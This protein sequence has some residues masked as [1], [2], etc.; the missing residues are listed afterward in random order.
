MAWQDRL[1]EAAY[2]SP[3]GQRFTFSYEN[4]SKSVTKR[5]SA[6]NFPDADGTYIQDL[7]RTGRRYPMRL[8]FHGDNYDLEAAAFDAALLEVGAGRLEH[9]MYGTVDVVPFGDITRRDDLKT[10]ANQAIIEVKFWE[11]TDILLPS[12]Q[13]DP[14]TGVLNAISE[15]N[16]AAAGQFEE[17][18][19]LDNAS[20]VASFKNRF[21]AVLDTTGATLKGVAEA[22]DDVRQ[23][24][25]AVYDSVNSS[26]D[27][28]VSEPLTL[29]TQTLIFIQTPARALAN[30]RARLSAYSDMAGALISGPNAI[31]TPSL[32]ASNSNA[33][34]N[35]NLYASTA[36]TGAVVSVVN[37]TFETKTE[38]LEAAE[39]I[40]DLAEQVNTWRDDNLV[41][42]SEIDTGEAYQQLQEAV[43]LA[44]GF[45]VQ[46]SFSLKQE[47]RIVLDRAR[48][49]VDLVAGLYGEVDTQLDFLINS[50]SLT[51]SEILELPKGR[52]IVYFI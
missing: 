11:T 6:F 30:I 34:R 3:S 24:F 19:V 44:A 39:D 7:G 10:A 20:E 29:A 27:T 28:L 52:E 35:D 42:L 46:I 22:Q 49:I 5:T 17:E 15:Y 18:L 33:F 8:F 23:Q 38:A 1:K 45:L 31:R 25:N 41:S 14:A 32:N 12:V 51:G 36:I 16:A 40:L 47:R 48:S 43:A 13:A 4:V 37:N 50:N 26:I 9:P 21:S 2:T